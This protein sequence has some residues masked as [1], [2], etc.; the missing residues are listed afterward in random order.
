V[1]RQPAETARQAASNVGNSDALAIG[2][3]V[4]L[5]SFGLV[6]LLIAWIALQTAWSHESQSANSSGALRELAQQPLGKVLV[7]VVVVGLLALVLWQVVEAIWGHSSEEGKK[8]LVKR[9]SSAGRAV[10]YA[11]LAFS[12]FGIVTGSGGGSSSLD[13]Q[14][15]DL[16]SVTGGQL[17]VGLIGLGVAAVGIV[18]VVRGFKASFTH[19]LQPRATS[20]NS[21]RIVVRLGQ[22]GYV[23]KGVSLAVVGSLF[24]A[25]AWTYDAQKAGG[26]DVALSTLLDQP[27]GRWLLTLVALGFAAFGA[28]CFTWARYPRE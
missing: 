16:M 14:T 7:W 4:G 13:S 18:F 6:H 9:L 24:L 15:A 12:A 1:A 21:G 23:A 3:R 19:H 28:Y 17:I 27:Y 5:A 11:A 10:V 8:R 2:I 26:L 22:A 20:G 25:A